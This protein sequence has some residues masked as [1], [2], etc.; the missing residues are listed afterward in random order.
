MM[1][2]QAFSLFENIDSEQS[3]KKEA[4]CLLLHHFKLGLHPNLSIPKYIVF[5][6]D[7]LL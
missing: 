5:V 1:I 6:G 2:D 3:I 4:I 7:Q